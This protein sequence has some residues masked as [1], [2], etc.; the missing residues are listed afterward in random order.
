MEYVDLKQVSLNVKK[1]PLA[2]DNFFNLLKLLAQ[3]RL[4]IDIRYFPRIIYSLFLSSA[5]SPFRISERLKF[6]NKI[7]NVEIN[8]SPVFL[9]GH[10]RS[11]TTDL[12]NL[13]SL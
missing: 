2:G 4:K 9:L 6:D 13:F 10:W 5:T 8:E 7:N 1:E 12:H 3:N 11:G